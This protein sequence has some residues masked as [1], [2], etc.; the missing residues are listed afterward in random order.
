MKIVG[1][2]L[3]AELVVIETGMKTLRSTWYR[4]RMMNADID[5]LA[6]ICGDESYCDV[7]VL[8]HSCHYGMKL[9]CFTIPGS[10]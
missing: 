5:G 6:H 7:G 9:C 1:A 3:G 10:A 4:Q 2:I 8:G